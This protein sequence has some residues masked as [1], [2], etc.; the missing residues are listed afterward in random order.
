MSTGQAAREAKGKARD[1]SSSRSFR[2][3]VT[4]GLCVVGCVHIL[5]GVL[6]LQMAWSGSPDKEADQKGALQALSANPVGGVL[7]WIVAV[8]LCGLVVW[9]LTQAW[10]GFGYESKRVARIRRRLGAVGG[11]GMYLVLA[12]TAIR[13]SLGE[14]TQ[15]G[16]SAQ[17]TRIGILLSQPY[18]QILAVVAAAVVIG[19]A[20]ILVKRGITGSFTKELDGEPAPAM[21]RFGQVGFVAKGVAVA[22]M[23]VLFGWAAVTYD[24]EKAAGMDDSL[25]LVNQQSAGPVL[26]TMIALGLI[27]YGLYCFSWARHARH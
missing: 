17:Q 21:K 14:K 3:L 25:R 27:A 19:Y 15:S 10:W 5:I 24:P 26:L 1:V 7:L 11:A 9:K 23:G 16:D 12:V 13:Y 20:A 6:A 2:A 4:A 8:A 18:G 22:L